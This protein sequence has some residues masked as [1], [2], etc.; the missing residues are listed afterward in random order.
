[1][2]SNMPN[3][4]DFDDQDFDNQDFDNQ[5]FDESDDDW[6]LDL[7]AHLGLERDESDEDIDYLIED[8]ADGAPFDELDDDELLASAGAAEPPM[9]RLERV[10]TALIAQPGQLDAHDIFALSDLSREGAAAVRAKWTAIPVERR[11]GLVHQLVELAEDDLDVHLGQLLRIALKDEDAK[12]RE[13]AV[14]GLWE[15]IAPDLIGEF[16]QILNH[17]PAR[18]VREAAAQALGPYILAGELDELDAALAMRVENAL[19]AVLENP[20]EDLEVQ[21]RALESIAYSGEIGVRQLIEDAYYAPDDEMRV[22]ALVAMGR[23]ADVRWR[24]LVRAELQN[25]AVEMRMQAAVASGELDAKVALPDLLALLS[26]HEPSVRMA[27]IFALGRIG[28]KDAVDALQTVLIG[29]DAKEA[30]AAEMALEEMSFYADP[31][32]VAL[33]DERL[34]EDAGWDDDP[35]DDWYDND[36]LDLGDYEE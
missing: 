15:E 18:S 33:F 4:N 21:C 35:L 19:L 14:I 7:D 26:D 22:S 28:G 3:P 6:D 29:D 16:V 31:E 25:P 34:D 30:A 5:D 9:I 13:A 1:M 12:V 23:S 11:R 8:L 10:L 2:R 20:D 36:E 24:G 27:T 17:D 32:A